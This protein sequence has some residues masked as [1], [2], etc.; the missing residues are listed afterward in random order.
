MEVEAEAEV[1]DGHPELGGEDEE[2]AAD[3]VLEDQTKESRT[4]VGQ[5]HQQGTVC[6]LQ[7]AVCILSLK[8]FDI[9][10]HEMI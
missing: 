2:A 6:R 3:Q 10:F 9:F 8:Y 4:R 7:G 5:T 1:G